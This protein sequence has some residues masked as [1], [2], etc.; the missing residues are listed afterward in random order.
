MAEESGLDPPTGTLS[1]ET[2]E[3]TELVEA[4]VAHRAKLTVQTLPRSAHL[5]EARR[6]I[7]ERNTREG[8]RKVRVTEIMARLGLD[9]DKPAPPEY[10]TALRWVADTH[11]AGAL[12][13]PPNGG[14]ET[15]LGLR[16]LGVLKEV[17]ALL[18]DDRV[19]KAGAALSLRNQALG[20]Q[21][22]ADDLERAL[23]AREATEKHNAEVAAADAKAKRIAEARRLKAALAELEAEETASHV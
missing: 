3:E 4:L 19:G 10:E 11:S 14:W 7:A 20:Y 2:P 21:K 13:S 23:A 22:R 12:A 6:L 9:P 18:E 17:E 16:S 8:A 1:N 15:P 5:A